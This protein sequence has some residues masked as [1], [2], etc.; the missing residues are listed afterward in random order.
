ML[1]FTQDQ[2]TLMCRIILFVKKLRAELLI[3]FMYLRT[4]ILLMYLLKPCRNPST[5]SL[6]RIL[7]CLRLEG[8]CWNNYRITRTWIYMATRGIPEIPDLCHRGC[9][10]HSWP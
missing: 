10:T 3:L 5:R 1:N 7:G 4:I 9:S 2:S 8:V 6:G